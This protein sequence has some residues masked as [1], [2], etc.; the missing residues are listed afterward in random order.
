[1]DDE[2]NLL[3]RQEKRTIVVLVA[4]SLL[5]IVGVTSAIFLKKH[6][7]PIEEA[8]EAAISALTGVAVDLTP[9]SRE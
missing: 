5:G 9:Q 6:D 1:M 2:K 4:V 3:S 8:S 7:A